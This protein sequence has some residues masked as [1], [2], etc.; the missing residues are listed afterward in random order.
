MTDQE[1]QP[2][3]GQLLRARREDVGLSQVQLAALA[4]VHRGT[5]RNA[6]HGRPIEVRT[7]ANVL[8]SLGCAPVVAY[9]N[10]DAPGSIKPVL[11]ASLVSMVA[12]TLHDIGVSKEGEDY[13]ISGVY[14]ELVDAV[15]AAKDGYGRGRVSLPARFDDLRRVL[16]HE[17]SNRQLA[18]FDEELQAV[19]GDEYPY[20][21]TVVTAQPGHATAG[22]PQETIVT[23]EPGRAQTG[24]S[25]VD[26]A[27]P[28][29][30]VKRVNLQ[31]AREADDARPLGIEVNSA[32][33]PHRAGEARAAEAR[34]NFR[35]RGTIRDIGGDLDYIRSVGL[36]QSEE[37]TVIGWLINRRALL[38][39]ELEL[40]I[41]TLRKVREEREAGVM[42]DDQGA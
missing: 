7:I 9:E 30:V 28:M 25:S 36:T 24:G 16:S 19:F 15:A 5:I 18:A 23:S 31:P 20:R 41:G 39:E 13:P 26:R 32:T 3:F 10:R 34:D 38:A 6:E 35:A 22:A 14:Y 11:S 29:R 40:M 42:D 8:R 21:H 17:F 33:H 12:S 27:M 37:E 4:G 2:V 1:E